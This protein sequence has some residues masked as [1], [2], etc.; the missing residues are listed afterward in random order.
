VSVR[1]VGW[2]GIVRGVWREMIGPRNSVVAHLRGEPYNVILDDSEWI[3]SACLY[4]HELPEV[5]IDKIH[6]FVGE[7]FG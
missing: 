7:D 4:W 1:V 2:V 6:D 3:N 5:W